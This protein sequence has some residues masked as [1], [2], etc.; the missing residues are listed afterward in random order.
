MYVGFQY[1]RKHG[2]V[3]TILIGFSLQFYIFGIFGAFK[4]LPELAYAIKSEENPLID[5][6]SLAPL[7]VGIALFILSTIASIL[8][9]KRL[10]KQQ[11]VESEA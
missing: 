3:S 9:R 5:F 4:V 7:F 2:V 1:Y 10:E 11:S 6:S 8:H